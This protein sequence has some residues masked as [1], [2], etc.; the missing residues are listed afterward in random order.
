MSY[1]IEYH[2][3]VVKKDIP[4]LGVSIKDRIKK[5]IEEKLLVAPEKFGKPLRKSLKNNRKLRVGDYRV[6]FRIEK[7]KVK[8]FK[9]GHRSIAYKG[10]WNRF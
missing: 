9:I 6:I 8:I 1:E 10:F 2:E 4:K 7:K 5:S 3:S